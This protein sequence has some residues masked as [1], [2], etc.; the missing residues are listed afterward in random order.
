MDHRQ[1][2]PRLALAQQQ[3]GSQ[4]VPGGAHQGSCSFSVAA[5]HRYLELTAI[6]VL[7]FGM[8]GVQGAIEV[9]RPHQ[10]DAM[11]LEGKS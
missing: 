2:K 4:P 5:S 10:V 11:E 6:A 1:A 7:L 3:M 9:V 8:G